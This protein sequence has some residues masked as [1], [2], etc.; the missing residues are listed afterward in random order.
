[1]PKTAAAVIEET[2][3]PA[4]ESPA[5]TGERLG[6]V[7]AIFGGVV[8]GR[9]SIPALENVLLTAN[10][11]TLT[12]VGTDLD[13]RLTCVLPCGSPA[14]SSLVE[15]RALQAAVNAFGKE[16]LGF[17][18]TD[19]KLFIRGKAGEFEI[20]SLPTDDFPAFRRPDPDVILEAPADALMRALKLCQPAISYE[21]TRYYLNGISMKMVDGRLELAAT[22]GHRLHLAHSPL[23]TVDGEM[24]QVIFR[25][26]GIRCLL[27]I[28]A[29]DS[30]RSDVLIEIAK[31]HGCFSVGKWLLET[32]FIDGTYPDY[33]RILPDASV[34]EL[35]LQSD[36]LSGPLKTIRK[37]GGESIKGAVLDPR[38]STIRFSSPEGF[39]FSQTFAG[40]VADRVPQ[41]IGFNARYATEILD[42]HPKTGVTIGFGAD[43]AQPI[44]FKFDNDEDFLAVLMPMR[45]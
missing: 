26:R 5:L 43:P 28:L 27:A 39:R 34:G 38:A 7:L 11:K 32:K 40:K 13:H 9:A 8:E 44:T 6:Q 14:F 31:L 20:F 4:A 42:T 22:D 35:S 17:F 1:M 23:L 45:V 10:G 19:D 25:T 24:P 2:P 33:T 36:D 16:E 30:S 29:G 15:H 3:S 37:L 41:S 18:A 21:E 12:V